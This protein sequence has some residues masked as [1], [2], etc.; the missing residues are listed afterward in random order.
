MP[1][2][3]HQEHAHEG[4][5]VEV[6]HTGPCTATVR[7]TVTAEEYSRTRDLGLKNVASRT[8]M[9]GFRPGKMPRAIVEKHFGPEVDREAIQH[10]LNHA[11]DIAVREHELR[12]AAHPRVDVASIT[13]PAAGAELQHSFEV[14]LRPKVQLGT[15]RGLRVASPPAEVS[16][17]ELEKTLEDLRR[18]NARP[19]PAGDEGLAEDGMAVCKV[20]FHVEGRE[21]PV[22]AREGLRL[23]PRTAPA[24]VD[25]EAYRQGLVGAKPGRTREFPL[26]IPEGFPERD[27]RGQ[28]ATCRISV[29]EVYRII[30]PTE[31]QLAETLKLAGVDAL[32]TELRARIQAAKEDQERFRIEN[33]LLD[34]LLEEHPME[35]PAPLLEAQADARVEELRQSLAEQGFA[36]EETE[37]RLAEERKQALQGSSRAM[38]AVYLMEEIA[39]AESIKVGESDLVAEMRSIA[40]RNQTEFE[41]VR[42]YYRQ[43]GLL[44]QLALELLERKVRS[45]LRESADIQPA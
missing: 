43:E 36:A 44:Q 8:R 7:F 25:V 24:G 5:E 27:V 15:Y 33:E 29:G 40:E 10:F 1:D 6:E 34:R 13:A 14:W 37:E 17:E 9:K 32:R 3:P 19:E 21:E 28:K 30:V 22:L 39:K 20:S 45:F 23:S 2:S 41:E 11:Y 38:R 31:E 16:D 42:K 35:L 18:Q 4:F 26:V 12:P